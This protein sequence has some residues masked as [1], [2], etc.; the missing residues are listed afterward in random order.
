MF[1]ETFS[2]FFPEVALNHGSNLI[3]NATFDVKN[4][5]NIWFLTINF[6]FPVPEASVPAVEICSERS[7]AGITFSARETLQV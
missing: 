5:I 2:I 4:T 3:K 6:I 7:A 1:Q